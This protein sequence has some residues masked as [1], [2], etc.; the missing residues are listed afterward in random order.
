MEKRRL[1]WVED[2]GSDL[3]SLCTLSGRK[4]SFIC[5]YQRLLFFVRSC[6]IFS[7]ITFPRKT[8]LWC[9]SSQH[10]VSPQ[11]WQTKIWCKNR[12]FSQSVC[13]AFARQVYYGET[14]TGFSLGQY[15]GQISEKT[16]KLF[17]ASCHSLASWGDDTIFLML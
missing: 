3:K 10:R 7:C 9:V 12:I 15:T 14:S 1:S 13:S 17:E 6:L 8:F 5:I 2:P 11:T 4:R 16:R